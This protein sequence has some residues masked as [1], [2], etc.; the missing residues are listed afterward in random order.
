MIV[1]LGP[2]GCGKS[3][4]ISAL[5]ASPPGCFK[6]VTTYHL[7]PRC[8]LKNTDSTPVTQPHAQGPR[9]AFLSTIKIFYFLLDYTV[10]WLVNLYSQRTERSLTVFDR[11]YHDMLVDPRRYRYGGPMW[12]ARWVGKLIPKPDLWILLDAPPDVLQTRKQ[13]VPFK[14]SARQGEEYLKLVKGMENGVIID[15]TKSLDEVIG[16]VN[17]VI[18]DSMAKRTENRLEL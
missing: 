13:E 15:A 9:G 2:D 1:L 5:E 11:Y 4:V 12:L 7:R 17:R 14:E 8:F 18:V 3:S 10:G 6:R 16:E